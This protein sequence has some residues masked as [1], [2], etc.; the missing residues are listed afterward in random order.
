MPWEKLAYLLQHESTG[1]SLNTEVAPKKLVEPTPNLKD[2]SFKE[3]HA[4]N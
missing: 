4:G 3:L 1:C 2:M